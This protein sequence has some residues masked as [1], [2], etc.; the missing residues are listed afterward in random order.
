VGGADVGGSSS[1]GLRPW[2]RMRE[3][4]RAWARRVRDDVLAVYFCARHPDTPWAP[5]L[6][7]LLIAAYALS[8]IDLIPDFIP[9]LGFLDEAILLPGAIWVCLRLMPA[10]VLAECRTQA[11]AWLAQQ[12]RKPRSVAGAVLVVLL[13][14]LLLWL[15]W[16]AIRTA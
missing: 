1:V 15:G 13:W 9:V 4:M 10:P 11:Q 12:R 6:V 2:R 3:R 8:P 5:K 16:L 14:V 7:A